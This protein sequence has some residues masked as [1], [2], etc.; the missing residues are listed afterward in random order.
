L[1]QR[2]RRALYVLDFDNTLVNT[3]AVINV[4]GYSYSF[5]QLNYYSAASA[6]FKKIL[7]RGS[8]TCILSSRHKKHKQE[9]AESVRREFGKEIPVF[10]VPRHFLKW[11]WVHWWSVRYHYVLVID[12]MMKGEETGEPTDLLFPGCLSS[13]IKVRRGHRVVRWRSI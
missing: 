13:R 11:F 7:D 3:A 4:N 12:D 6:K 2:R 5:D 1:A 10:L 9:I 8:P